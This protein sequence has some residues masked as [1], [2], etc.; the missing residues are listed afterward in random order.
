MDFLVMA[1]GLFSLCLFFGICGKQRK[2]VKAM[3]LNSV[4]GLAALTVAAAATG[5]LG[6][7]IAFNCATAL[8]AVTLGIPGVIAIIL[9]KFI[10]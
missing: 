10:I 1:L 7:G 5:F 2:P 6:C 4:S 9:I 8:T 3:I